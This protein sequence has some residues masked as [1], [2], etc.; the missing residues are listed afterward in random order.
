MLL[1]AW[2]A[3]A[4]PAPKAIPVASVLPNPDMIPG[5][6]DIGCIVAGMGLV[7]VYELLDDGPLELK[8]P[9]REPDLGICFCIMNN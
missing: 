8:P 6:R 9:E 7:A 4:E 1:I 5:E 3:T 2:W